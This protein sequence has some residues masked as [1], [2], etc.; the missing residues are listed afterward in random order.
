ML[1]LQEQLI[2]LKSEAVRWLAW[3]AAGLAHRVWWC[4][5]L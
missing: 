4:E 5:Y 2:Q 1:V 3:Q